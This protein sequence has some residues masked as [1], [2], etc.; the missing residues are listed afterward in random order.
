MNNRILKLLKDERGAVTVDWIVLTAG[1]VGI[2]VT[3]AST[4]D[5]GLQDTVA[6]I[7]ERLNEI[8]ADLEE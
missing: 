3:M 6:T 2:G 4:L 1:I 5:A 7:F 8:V